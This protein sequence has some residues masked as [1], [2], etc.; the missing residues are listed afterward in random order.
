MATEE[1]QGN[2]VKVLVTERP[3]A[4]PDG[5]V[6]VTPP[7]RSNVIVEAMTPFAQAG[8]RFIRTYLQGLVG[9]LMV[10]LAAA[11]TLA[12][13]G[14]VVEPGDFSEAF[15]KSAGLA[16]APAAVSLL[17]NLVEIFTRIDERFPK[18]RA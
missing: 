3:G 8:V 11:P 18:A 15:W 16:L 9:F 7:Y 2:E 14:V 1:L 17:Q 6:L 10:A 5:A 4:P 13:V 12:N